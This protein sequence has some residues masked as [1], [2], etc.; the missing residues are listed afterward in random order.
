MNQLTEIEW[1]TC[2][3]AIRYA[4]NRQTISSAMLPSQLVEAYWERWSDDQKQFIA[5]DLQRKIDT[6]EALGLKSFG[7]P[8]IDRIHWMRFMSACNLKNHCNVTDIEGHTHKCFKA[9]D[10]IYPLEEYVKKPY[11]EIWLPDESIESIG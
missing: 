7:N 4:M 9:N 2:I 8:G 1:E 3:M 10:K 11:R 6:Q 5:D